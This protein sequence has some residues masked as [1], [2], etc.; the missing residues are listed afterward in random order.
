MSLWLSTVLDLGP[1]TKF[2]FVTTTNNNKQKKLVKIAGMLKIMSA[3]DICA[4]SA[5]A[6]VTGKQG[7]E[8]ELIKL[9]KI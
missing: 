5:C 3:V 4:A 7:E 8:K 6:N 2:V 9:I 1:V